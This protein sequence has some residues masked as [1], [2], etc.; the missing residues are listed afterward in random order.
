[1]S[2]VTLRPELLS[3]EPSAHLEALAVADGVEGQGIGQMLLK[4][5]EAGA[6]ANGAKTMTLHVFA[7]NTRA[8]K[9][10]ERFGYDGELVR[11][12]KPIGA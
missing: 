6:A 7:T 11:Y 8:R 10:Y 2:M 9:L 4:A 12:I 5:A 3:Q 1:M